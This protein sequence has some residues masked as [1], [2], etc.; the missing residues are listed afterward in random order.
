M[1]DAS[2]ADNG[3]SGVHASPPVPVTMPSLP[4]PLTCLRRS[5]ADVNPRKPLSPRSVARPVGLVAVLAGASIALS[6]C[7]GPPTSSRETLEELA[8]ASGSSSFAFVRESFDT[9][10]VVDAPDGPQAWIRDSEGVSADVDRGEPWWQPNVPEA[11]LTM[12]EI[13]DAWEVVPRCDGRLSRSI[14]PVG[15]GH[16]LVVSECSGPSE[17]A[18]QRLPAQYFDGMLVR[19]GEVDLLDASH[20]AEKIALASDVVGGV[21]PSS[22]AL[23]IDGVHETITLV[24]AAGGRTTDM[25]GDPCVPVF[26]FQD[27]ITETSGDS[28]RAAC[29]DQ[30]RPLPA[31]P[32]DP[33]L[34]MDLWRD[35]GGESV[36][37]GGRIRFEVDPQ[38]GE[39]NYLIKVGE[40]PWE[41]FDSDGARQGD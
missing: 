17:S 12:D 10:A 16:H 40:G 31:T 30:Q 39:A 2:G 25:A 28:Y 21:D 6:G 11:V 1:T 36:R 37:S 34:A 3:L 9:L 33:E 29:G 22:V 24:A 13:V 18:H 38:S 14:R 32:F 41:Y 26:V 35:A 23:T 27:T 7:G 5:G 8:E 15:A 4:P 20:L 19:N